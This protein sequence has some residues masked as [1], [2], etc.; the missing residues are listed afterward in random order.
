[1]PPEKPKMPKETK[2]DLMGEVM[3]TL[4]DTHG[5]TESALL[6]ILNYFTTVDLIGIRADLKKELGR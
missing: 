3:K 4:K 6:F 1:M 5:N 2:A